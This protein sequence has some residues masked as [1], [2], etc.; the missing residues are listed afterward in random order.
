MSLPN[1]PTPMIPQTQ[2]YWLQN[3]HI[4][5]ALID[6]D[7]SFSV[8]R[9][10]FSL[11]D[12]EIKDGK[13]QQ[14]LAAQE[15]QPIIEQLDL[16]KKIILPNFVDIHTHLDKGHIWERSPNKTGTFDDALATVQGDHVRWQPEDLYRR[17]SFGLQTSY[18]HGTRAIRTHLDSFGG[19]GAVSFEV[20][21]ALRDE[22]AD[23]ITLEAVCLVGIDYFLTD[24]GIQLADLVAETG[25]ILGGVVY[26][27]PQMD[28]Q[29][30]RIFALAKERNLNL[31]LHTDETDDPASNGL[32][33]IAAAALRH[34]FTG[35][36]LCGHCC[37]LAVQSPE[38]REKTLTLVKQANLGV[39]SL[40]MCNLFLQDRKA[41]QTPLWRGITHVHELKNQG[42][43]VMF[44]SDNCRD[45]FY[46]FGD[47]DGLEV[48]RESVR[49]AHLDTPYGDWCTSVTKTPAD[50]MGLTTLGRIKVGLSADFIVFNARYWSELLSRPQSDR[51]LV[52]QGKAIQVSLPDYSELDDLIEI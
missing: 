41:Q 52:R 28:E 49:I 14:I 11:V 24:E 46:G 21:A 20:F 34:Q 8:D 9:D 45:P 5:A 12:L 22:W 13:I 2:H 23:R 47:H 39:V 50:W 10:G 38:Q 29:L 33:R 51:V 18:A 15:Q 1:L 17:M 31:D 25:A 32:E 7:R 37:S 26:L 3:A 44:A 16:K 36:V 27:D 35:K 19:M 42:N 4:P 6:G 43:A 30:D 40:P 48:F